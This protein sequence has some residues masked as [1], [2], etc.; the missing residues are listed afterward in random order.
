MNASHYSQYGRR[1]PNFEVSRE[2][3]NTE[4]PKTNK[5]E[6]EFETDSDT[7]L[8]K[9]ST[10]VAGRRRRGNTQI[11][12]KH[13]VNGGMFPVTCSNAGSDHVMMFYIRICLIKRIIGS[14]YTEFN[15]GLR[16]GGSLSVSHNSTL[17]GVY[18]KY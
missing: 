14:R 1:S 17:A 13:L 15:G 7:D 16:P 3:A 4:T 2:R 6:S 9:S 18:L 5:A 11:H 12:P 8:T 10:C